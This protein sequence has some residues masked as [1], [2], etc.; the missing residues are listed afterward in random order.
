MFVIGPLNNIAVVKKDMN[1][2]MRTFSMSKIM[3]VIKLETRWGEQKKA[4]HL[5]WSKVYPRF[6][7]NTASLHDETLL[8]V[9]KL[10]IRLGKWRKQFQ[11]FFSLQ[12]LFLFTLL[13]YISGLSE[14]Y[15]NHFGQCCFE[16]YFLKL[17]YSFQFRIFLCSDLH[18]QTSEVR[19]SDV[20]ILLRRT[21]FLMNCSLILLV[22]A[23]HASVCNLWCDHLS[24]WQAYIPTHSTGQAHYIHSQVIN[25]AAGTHQNRNQPLSF[26][27]PSGP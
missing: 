23:I 12:L 19:D 24:V 26:Q 2:H 20:E 3:E 17:C 9:H 16:R 18:Y 1:N 14:L 22:L 8:I 5:L 11:F 27:C 10:T 7:L 4:S 21:M 13:S 25:S 15:W 6:T